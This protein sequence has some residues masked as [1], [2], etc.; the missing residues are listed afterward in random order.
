MKTKT[1]RNLS[2]RRVVGFQVIEDECIW[3]KAGVVNFRKCDQAYDCSHCAFDKAMR[4]AMR[5]G[6]QADTERIAPEW[7]RHLRA[8]HDGASLPCRH[9]LTGRV[10]APKICVLDYECHRC[11]YDQMLDEMDLHRLTH[12]PDY[13]TVSGYQMAR[14]C[15]YHRGHS[16]VRFEH[17]G[18]ARIGFDAFAVNLFGAFGAIEMPSLGTCLTQDRVGWAFTRETHWAAMLAP[19][20]GTVVALNQRVNDYPEIIHED[21]YHLG[22]L[23]ILEPERAKKN[24]RDLYFGDAGSRW[25]ELEVAALMRMIGAEYEGLA[26]AAGKPIGDVFG[27]IPG[28]DWRLLV[29]TFLR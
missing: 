10:E 19:V 5:V 26:A 27:Q 6:D 4:R 8:A 20:S 22:W 29:K 28:L 13:T 15:Y 14:D 21:P 9:A 23:F 18:L 17:G 1:D 11:E 24:L 16:W 25:M 12:P 7:A 2:H 3:M